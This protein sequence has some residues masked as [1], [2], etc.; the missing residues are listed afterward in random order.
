MSQH[1]QTPIPASPLPRGVYIERFL[2][3]GHRWV[4]SVDSRGEQMALRCPLEDDVQ[5]TADEL[6]E[7]LDRLDPIPTRAP[8]RVSLP[9]LRLI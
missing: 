7:E 5:A 6:W 4:Y 3:N 1:Y 9:R 8:S 2:V